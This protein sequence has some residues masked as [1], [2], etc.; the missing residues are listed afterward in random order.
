M[1]ITFL[2]A[3]KFIIYI[4]IKALAIIYYI[5]SN[6]IKIILYNEKIY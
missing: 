6:F 4:D 3:L 2:I 1:I 5:H